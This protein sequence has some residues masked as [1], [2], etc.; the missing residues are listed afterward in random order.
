M[1]VLLSCAPPIKGLPPTI[2][3]VLF[4]GASAFN[5]SYS[6]S[7]VVG[8]LSGIDMWF[9]SRRWETCRVWWNTPVI[10]EAEWISSSKSAW[11]HEF[12]DS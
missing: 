12:S 2:L 4:V 5:T 6:C 11:V 7:R 10:P 9:P 1:K 8:K 3:S